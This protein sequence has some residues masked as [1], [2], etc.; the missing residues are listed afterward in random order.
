MAYVS[1][2]H[3]LAHKLLAGQ[4]LDGLGSTFRVHHHDES[5]STRVLG[6][7]VIHDRRLVDLERTGRSDISGK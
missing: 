5:E 6:V 4:L 7:R 1:N 3:D 2:G